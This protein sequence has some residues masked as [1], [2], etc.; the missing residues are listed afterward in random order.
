MSGF[1]NTASGATSTAS[2]SGGTFAYNGLISGFFNNGVTAA[3]LTLPAGVLS[4]VGSGLLNSN[5]GF[6]A[7]FNLQKALKG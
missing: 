7:L 2:A 4:G 1:F 5:T 3:L 6:S